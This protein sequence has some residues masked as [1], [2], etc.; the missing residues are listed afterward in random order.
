[1]DFKMELSISP[2]LRSP[3]S[4]QKI[5]K[6]IQTQKIFHMFKLPFERTLEEAKNLFKATLFRLLSVK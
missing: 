4:L 1:M 3:N 2:C 5:R 6:T